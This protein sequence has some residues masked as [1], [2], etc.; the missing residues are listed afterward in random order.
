MKKIFAVIDAMSPRLRIALT[1]ALLA[2]PLLYTVLVHEQRFASGTRVVLAT[3]PVDPR[4]LMQ[5]DYVILSYDFSTITRERFADYGSLHEGQTIYAVMAP[6]QP[7]WQF[8]EAYTARPKL[9]PGQVVMRGTVSRAF[10]SH[11]QVVYGLEQF[12][13]PE[14][15]GR[16]IELLRNRSNSERLTVEA[17]VSSDG[18]AS[19]SRLLVDGQP[20]F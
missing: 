9:E 11:L 16:W 13:V 18:K 5:G 20:A 6:G 12:F 10:S 17:V 2:L 3:T 7:T 1:V 14:G 15:E 19:L 4:T 8:I